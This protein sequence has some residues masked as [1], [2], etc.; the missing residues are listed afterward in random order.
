[1]NL[2]HLETIPC[3]QSMEKMVFHEI[4]SWCQKKGWEPMT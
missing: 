4:S 1:M 3:P 2:N